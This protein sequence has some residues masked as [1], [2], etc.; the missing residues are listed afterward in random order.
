M[1]KGLGVCQY[2]SIILL[3]KQTSKKSSHGHEYVFKFQKKIS[4]H[5]TIG[6][7]EVIKKHPMFHRSYKRYGNIW[8]ELRSEKNPNHQK[9]PEATLLI[10]TDFVYLM[11]KAKSPT[12]WHNLGG[13]RDFIQDD[14][15]FIC[16]GTFYSCTK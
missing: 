13:L 1:C 3:M 9:P 4:P 6:I 7:I 16:E 5:K 11:R 12:I 2:I 15:D 14:L 8:Y 10:S